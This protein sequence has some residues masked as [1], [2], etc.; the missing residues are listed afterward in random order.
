MLKIASG[1]FKGR[2]LKSPSGD[3]T[4]PTSEKVRQAVFNSLQNDVEGSTFLDLYAGSG[5]MGL[6]AISNGAKMSVFVEKNKAVADVI[7]SNLLDL[8]VEDNSL[9]L[10]NSAIRAITHLE[11]TVLTFDIIYIDPPY[12]DVESAEEE[13]QKVLH[14]LDKSTI[15]QS[16]GKLYLEF[17]SHSKL[18]FSK[19][20]FKRLKLKTTKAY[21]RS[22]LVIFT[23]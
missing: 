19:L 10:M 1:S 2:K 16:S 4:R 14:E 5:A 11:C 8:D 17:S 21:G 12:E 22:K 20:N 23:Y 9:I 18:D 15:L 13:V 6:E 7:E 3:T